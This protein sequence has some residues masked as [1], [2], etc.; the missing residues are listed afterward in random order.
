M[1][2]STRLKTWTIT[3]CLN[4]QHDVSFPCKISFLIKKNTTKTEYETMTNW[5][6][7][8]QDLCKR[9]LNKFRKYRLGK[10]NLVVF[11][12]N[13]SIL[14]EINLNLMA[15]RAIIDDDDESDDNVKNDFEEDDQI[16]EQYTA[17]MTDLKDYRI[18]DGCTLYVAKKGEA[19]SLDIKNISNNKSDKNN[20]NND[21]EK[22]CLLIQRLPNK[23]NK[24]LGSIVGYRGGNIRNIVGSSNIEGALLI[25]EDK[26]HKKAQCK[27][28]LQ[29]EQQWNK[30]FVHNNNQ[31]D[32]QSLIYSQLIEEDLKQQEEQ[33][34][35]LIE[36]EQK[37]QEQRQRRQNA[38]ENNKNT[39]RNRNK[40]R[41]K[42]RKRREKKMNDGIDIININKSKKDQ[43]KPVIVMRGNKKNLL[44]AKEK[45]DLVLNNRDLHKG[46][47]FN[48][49]NGD[50]TIEEIKEIRER[51]VPVSSQKGGRKTIKA[52]KLVRIAKHFA[53]MNGIEKSW[54]I[55]GIKKLN[56][57]KITRGI[58]DDIVPKGIIF[59]VLYV[60]CSLDALDSVV[61]T[62]TQRHVNFERVVDDAVEV[63]IDVNDGATDAEVSDGD[64]SSDDA[65][66]N[67]ESNVVDEESSDRYSD[68]N[69]DEIN[70]MDFNIVYV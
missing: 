29:I 13:G 51:A 12:Q 70:P 18:F 50:S 55:D 2:S 65:E 41:K 7:F 52:N 15:K 1:E 37:Q 14:S 28:F 64:E 5:P 45:L 57:L 56:Q 8:K 60:R 40:K 4:R 49:L 47:W 19:F 62:L 61:N 69:S 16:K 63:A 20:N 25:E 9:I 33:Q 6:Y 66:N 35:K 43:N 68:S 36:L 38:I 24:L 53:R 3:L 21:N 27:E 30:N 23:S 48:L 34:Q 58:I 32:P 67:D 22:D 44:K 59:P 39:N 31:I 46:Y 10:K 26:P 54:Y 42:R 17:R 11:T